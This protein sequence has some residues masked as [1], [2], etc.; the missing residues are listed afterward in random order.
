MPPT[1]LSFLPASDPWVAYSKL[2]KSSGVMAFSKPDHG[3]EALVVGRVIV[4]V[5][6]Y[7]DLIE[8]FKS[9]KVDDIQIVL[10]VAGLSDSTPPAWDISANTK[11]LIEYVEIDLEYPQLQH[12]AM[13]AFVE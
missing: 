11:L 4:D 13:G 5:D 12:S 7:A 9:V 10:T 6:T 1:S 3:I 2:D 8:A